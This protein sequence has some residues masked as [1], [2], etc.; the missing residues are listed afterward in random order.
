VA[1]ISLVET[2]NNEL[3]DPTTQKRS[4]P[5]ALGSGLDRIGL[6]LLFVIVD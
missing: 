3:I 2:I 4:R 6:D 5:L 1:N